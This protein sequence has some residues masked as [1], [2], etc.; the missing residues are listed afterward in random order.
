VISIIA[1]G[2]LL[3]LW[4]RAPRPPRIQWRVPIN[5]R[6]SERA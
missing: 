1:V 2:W 5:A 6:A 3:T 4:R